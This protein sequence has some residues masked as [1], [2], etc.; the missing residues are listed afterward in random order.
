MFNDEVLVTTVTIIVS[1]LGYFI[2]DCVLPNMGINCS[3]PAYLTTLGLFMTAFG[4]SAA[5]PET[6][7][8]V[9]NIW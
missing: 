3:N 5:Y 4:K 8:F 1:Y 2:A 9:N 6:E 7:E